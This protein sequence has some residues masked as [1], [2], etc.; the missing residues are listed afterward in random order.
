M[1]VDHEEGSRMAVEHLIDQ[2]HRRIAFLNGP[3]TYSNSLDRFKGYEKA[4]QQR[5][6]ERDDRL[7]FEG[8]FGRRSGYAI[9]DEIAKGLKRSMP[10]LLQM[11][12]WLSVCFRG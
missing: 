2:G 9:G 7:L 3:L 4:L 11:I 5:G 1:D 10:S 12:G 8:N 6:L